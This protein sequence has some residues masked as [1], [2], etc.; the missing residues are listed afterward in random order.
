M[1]VSLIVTILLS[2]ATSMIA[3]N[4]DFNFP[5][6][7]EFLAI[8]FS[9]FC[10]YRGI[11]KG[12]G[13]S[14]F[15]LLIGTF[16]L[17][18]ILALVPRFW[19]AANSSGVINKISACTDFNAMGQLECLLA[20]PFS[21]AHG[22]RQIL[23]HITALFITLGTAS[24]V[25]EISLKNKRHLLVF[26]LLPLTLFI[27]G[28]LLP[29]FFPSTDYSLNH[30]LV[31][32]VWKDKRASGIVAN[33]T[34]L[35][36]LLVPG[37]S[38]AL[39]YSVFGKWHQK[40][41]GAT[42]TLL[43]S[44]LLILSNQRGAILLC[45]FLISTLVAIALFGKL[46]KRYIII[47][48]GT[49]FAAASA[50]FMTFHGK[51]S[52]FLKIDQRPDLTSVS[53]SRLEMW[54]EAFKH[55]D[56][57]GKGFGT[58]WHEFSNLSANKP[59]LPVFDTAHNFFVQIIFELG[60]VHSLVIVSTL[61]IFFYF[62]LRF[63]NQNDKVF[64]SASIIAAVGTI[65]ALAF[66]EIDYI[67]T[68]YYQH[69]LFW[70][71]FCGGTTISKPDQNRRLKSSEFGLSLPFLWT[72]ISSGLLFLFYSANLSW[73]GSTFEPTK[74]TLASFRRWFR[75]NGIL[76]VAPSIKRETFVYFGFSPAEATNLTPKELFSNNVI[77]EIE[78][79]FYLETPRNRFS[80]LISYSTKKF[81]QDP[82]QQ[83]S[84]QITLPGIYTSTRLIQSYG[85]YPFEAEVIDNQK[86]LFK[87][88]QEVCWH[89]VAGSGS[90]NPRLKVRFPGILNIK[91]EN[92]VVDIKLTKITQ[93]NELTQKEIQE[94]LTSEEVE[95]KKFIFNNENSE[96]TLVPAKPLEKNDAWL[97]EFQ[98]GSSYV[99]KELGIN[100]DS[101]KLAIQIFYD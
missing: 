53:D 1:Y 82:H 96:V 6:A 7:F 38:L 41:I 43:A 90:E 88:C 23:F 71:V 60:Y 46:A 37:F 12:V 101:R 3:T 54:K 18:L 73:G 61:A 57:Q 84:F 76:A 44:L 40:M 36:P 29:R 16:F 81:H 11:K 63:K 31:S 5:G 51:L 97:V 55:F 15:E 70:G 69:A 45:G 59:D 52:S 42:L 21:S 13:L 94:I 32:G 50:L 58:W 9:A 49:F 67:P 19:F 8:S 89:L 30:W 91:N 33:P 100:A 24:L 2:F 66:Q 25:R 48:V 14:R 56:W 10:I 62:N 17:A 26:F 79:G 20:Q 72:S 35:W 47:I 68:V 86:K 75:P 83:R 64:H 74:E 65:I 92:L 99:P 80:K 78:G 34:W 22:L 77:S 98:S 27:G 39:S 28:S 93:A 4:P 87:W 95:K 85:T